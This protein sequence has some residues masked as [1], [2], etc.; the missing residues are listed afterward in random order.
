MHVAAKLTM[1]WGFSLEEE[2]FFASFLYDAPFGRNA[3]GQTYGRS[4][5]IIYVKF[6]SSVQKTDYDET[7]WRN[8]NILDSFSG[9]AAFGRRPGRTCPDKDFP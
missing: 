4:L 1:T 7:G 6:Y 5:V 9:Y 8:G 2:L 3:M